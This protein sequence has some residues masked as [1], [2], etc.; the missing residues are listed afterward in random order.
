MNKIN[1][2]QL[3]IQYFSLKF[4]LKFVHRK[5]IRAREKCMFQG[6]S[7]ESKNEPRTV[8]KC[9]QVWTANCKHN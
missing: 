9:D 8:F 1:L 7:Q 4:S 2:L 6:F 5:G 3:T